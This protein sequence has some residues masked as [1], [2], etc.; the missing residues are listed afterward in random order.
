[1][2]RVKEHLG[3]IILG[4][5]I[6]VAVIAPACCIIWARRRERRKYHPTS[7]SF[8]KAR[9]KLVAVAEYR[10]DTEKCL[11]GGDAEWTGNCP[12]C[13]G[14]LTAENNETTAED[15]RPNRGCRGMRD[16]QQRPRCVW[17]QQRNDDGSNSLDS[18]DNPAPARGPD[19]SFA[20][21]CRRAG[22]GERV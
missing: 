22:R 6:V 13:I 12:I 3:V 20:G 18:P 7:K 10:K 9:A 21:S 15:A 11:G 2:S 16:Q 5:F 19:G 17:K 8:R 14:P 4:V 1:M